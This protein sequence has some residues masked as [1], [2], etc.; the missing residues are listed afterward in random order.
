[1]FLL[2]VLIAPLDLVSLFLV[3]PLVAL[4]IAAAQ[5]S[6]TAA[7]LAV[8]LAALL[9]VLITTALSQALLAALGR[10]L[11]REWTRALFGLLVGMV[12]MLPTV[13]VRGLERQGADALPPRLVE[14]L[15]DIAAVF[16]WFPPTAL[17]VRAALAATDAHAGPAISYLAASLVLLLVLVNVGSRIA[18]REA[19]NRVAGG[20]TRAPATPPLN[21][22]PASVAAGPAR[23]ASDLAAMIGR[24]WRTYLRTPQ[25]LMGLLM[26]PVLLLVFGRGDHGFNF[27][28]HPFL[29]TFLCISSALNLSGNQFGLDQAGVRLLFLLPIAPRRLLLAKNLAL[30]ALVALVAA[31]CLGVAAAV[32]GLTVERALTTVASLAAAL[33]VALTLGSFLSV[34]HPWRMMFRLG[35]AP[36]GAMISAFSQLAALGVVAVLLLIPM[37][38]VPVLLASR[39]SDLWIHAATLGATLVFAGGLWATWWVLLGVAARALVRR[40]ELIIDRLAKPGETG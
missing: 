13:M 28:S 38:L 3:P 37:S 1:M 9:L 12:F 35:G 17:P 23:P 39:A 7:G 22:R 33:P 32:A 15:P 20:D 8:G 31:I 6:G 14:R 24:E 4:A 10:Y 40:R 2:N 19:M 30:V 21:A 11:R 27:A 18:V 25:V 36:P 16:A 34:Y 5:R 29:L 26:I